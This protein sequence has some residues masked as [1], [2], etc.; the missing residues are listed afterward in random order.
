M[1][2]RDALKVG[3]IIYKVDPQKLSVKTF[4]IS[5]PD[6]IVNFTTTTYENFWLQCEKQRFQI[7]LEEFPCQYDGYWYFMSED[8][9]MGFIKAQL[10]M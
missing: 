9:A 4:K 3:D 1:N 5:S 6:E 10:E 8:E 7:P 2:V